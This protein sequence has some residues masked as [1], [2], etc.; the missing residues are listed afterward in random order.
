MVTPIVVTATQGGTGTENGI[1]LTV[2]VLTGASTVQNGVTGSDSSTLTVPQK[3]ITPGTTGSVIYGAVIDGGSDTAL[4]VNAQSTSFQAISDTTNIDARGNFRATA[5]TTNGTPVTVGTA[6]PP[7]RVRA[8]STGARRR[9]STP[10][11]SRKT[12]VPP[13]G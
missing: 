10:G 12:P 13:R 7:G 9:S 3:A 1:T 6:P 5:T 8:P 11:P 4:G 2:K